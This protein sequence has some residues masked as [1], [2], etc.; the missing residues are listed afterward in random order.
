MRSTDCERASAAGD[1][2]NGESAVSTW[3]QKLFSCSQSNRFSFYSVVG[4]KE[5][6]RFN[7]C[8]DF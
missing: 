5:P 7:E 1:G 3:S 8:L 6:L 4:T 2:K